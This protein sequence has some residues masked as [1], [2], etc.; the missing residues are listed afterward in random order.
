MGRNGSPEHVPGGAERLRS[1]GAEYLEVDRG[2]SVTFHG[3]GQLVA[4]PIVL[5]A[6]VLP[7]PGHPAHGDVL[8]YVRALEEGLIGAAA[9]AGVPGDRRPPYTG[10]WVGEDK[11]AAIG[12]K[13]SRGVTLHGV[14]VNVTTDLGWFAQVVPC[15]IPGAGVTSLERLGAEGWTPRRLAPVLAGTLAA[16]LGLAAAPADRRLTELVA[17]PA[18][19]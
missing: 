18:A 14:A 9:A 12:V 16:A 4:Y 19:A 1:L 10:V 17:A 8:R 13:L 6:G 15:G 5:L 2:G 3:P 7:I 11:L